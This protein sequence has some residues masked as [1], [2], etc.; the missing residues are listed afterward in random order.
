MPKNINA[1][2]TF[3]AGALLTLAIVPALAQTLPCTKSCIL[4]DRKHKLDIVAGQAIDNNVYHQAAAGRA[5]AQWTLEPVPGDA[6]YYYLREGA[7]GQYIVAGDSY[8][9]RVYH[10]PSNNRDNAKWRFAPAPGGGYYILDKKFGKALVAGDTADNRIYHQDPNN[11]LNAAWTLIP[12]QALGALNIPGDFVLVDAKHN[13]AL[14]LGSV[15]DRINSVRA[16]HGNNVPADQ[17]FGPYT[18][19]RTEGDKI[20]IA[21]MTYPLYLAAGTVQDG[22]IYWLRYT[23]DSGAAATWGTRTDGCPAGYFRLEDKKHGMDVVAGDTYDGNVYHQ[24]ANNRANACWKAITRAQFE[25]QVADAFVKRTQRPGGTGMYQAGSG[26]LA[27]AMNITPP[28]TSFTYGSPSPGIQVGS[29]CKTPTSYGAPCTKWNRRCLIAWN[30]SPNPVMVIGASGNSNNV[31][32]TGSWMLVAPRSGRYFQAITDQRYA[33]C[34]G[35]TYNRS[36]T[37]Y[38]VGCGQATYVN[39]WTPPVGGNPYSYVYRW[40]VPSGNLY[41]GQSSDD[42]S[43]CPDALNLE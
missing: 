34:G 16:S 21:G 27:T 7:Y 22:N 39:Q 3:A 14:Y 43:D 15:N 11:R 17:T 25:R 31:A 28:P 42:N 29:Q 4:E 36:S 18:V 8:D 35:T 9:G 12:T 26:D 30:D 6:G 19:L 23:Q 37:S 24:P 40:T 20:R 41:I 38:P 32:T 13:A 33:S 5:V 1:L 2:R 10:Q